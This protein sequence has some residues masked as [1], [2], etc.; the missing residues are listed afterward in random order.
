MLK[1]KKPYVCNRKRYATLDEALAVA[2]RIHARTGV[3]VTV[4]HRP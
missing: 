1:I 3:F 4:E 2:K